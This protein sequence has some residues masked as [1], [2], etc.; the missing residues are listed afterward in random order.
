M[1]SFPSRCRRS[2]GFRIT[3]SAVVFRTRGKTQKLLKRFSSRV[4]KKGQMKTRGKFRNER[5]VK[6]TRRET[7]RPNE[8]TTRRRNDPS[9]FP[10]AHFTGIDSGE[11]TGN[12]CQRLRTTIY[13]TPVDN[14]FDSYVFMWKYIFIYLWRVYI[15][16]LLARPIDCADCGFIAVIAPTLFI[17]RARRPP[18]FFVCASNIYQQKKKLSDDD[19]SFARIAKRNVGRQRWTVETEETRCRTDSIKHDYRRKN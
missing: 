2:R 3:V 12:I 7:R 19:D 11:F 16:N 15:K 8:S 17:T 6:K 1:F 4:K 14:G 13:T 9:R 5:D 18:V 10:W